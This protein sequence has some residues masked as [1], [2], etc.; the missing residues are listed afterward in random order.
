[1]SLLFSPLSSSGK[2]LTERSDIQ[3]LSFKEVD[4]NSAG[5]SDEIVFDVPANIKSFLVQYTADSDYADI[6]FESLSD[7][8]GH[9]VMGKRVRQF[10]Y[11]N[12]SLKNEVPY[13]EWENPSAPSSI[14]G[15]ATALVGNNLDTRLIPGKWR[16]KFTCSAP[17]DECK[18]LKGLVQIIIKK[19]TNT[20][21]KATLP[22]R[23]YFPGK[24]LWTASSAAKNKD[25]KLF[26]KVLKDIF[27]LVN[28][29]VEVLSREDTPDTV[30]TDMAGGL[31]HMLKHSKND[32]VNIYFAK[33][34]FDWIGRGTVAVAYQLAGP[35][36]APYSTGVMIRMKTMMTRAELNHPNKMDYTAMD[37]VLSIPD[38]ALTTAHEIAH[39]LGLYHVCEAPAFNVPMGVR[40]P[41][42]SACDVKN[43]MYPSV[44]HANFHLTPAQAEVLKRH[45]LVY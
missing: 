42:N 13:L 22:L 34:N 11:I 32:A 1:M 28:I 16:L 24:S 31:Q 10:N 40:D 21:K 35:Y 27:A 45:P 25:F 2:A 38:Y 44:G 33:T 36:L 29:E 26:M 20:G 7:P 9:F 39:Y 5:K 19:N 17:H 15:M 18:K 43:M 4:F 23:L 6:D 30:F 12:E 3:V 14:T 41:L 8:N 37:S